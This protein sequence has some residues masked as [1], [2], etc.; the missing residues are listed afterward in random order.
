MRLRN[1]WNSL[2]M[3]GLVVVV[4]SGQG[5]VHSIE[6]N[7]VYPNNPY[8]IVEWRIGDKP[9]TDISHFTAPPDWWQHVSLIIKNI[10][11]KTIS[12]QTLYLTIPLSGKM[13]SAVGMTPQTDLREALVDSAQVPTGKLGYRWHPGQTLEF[14]LLDRDSSMWDKYLKSYDVTSVDKLFLDV[15]FIF[16]EDGTQYSFGRGSAS[17]AGQTSDP[18]KKVIQLRGWI[19][20][21]PVQLMSTA[22]NGRTIILD[23]AFSGGADWLAGATVRFK[24]ISA[25]TITCARFS[26]V[27]LESYPTGPPHAFPLTYGPPFCKLDVAK[28]IPPLAP[29]SIGEAVFSPGDYQRMKERLELTE[30][31]ETRTTAELHLTELYFAD[32][33]KWS[34]PFG[35]QRPDPDDPNRWMPEQKSL[36]LPKN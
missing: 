10:S 12:G 15:S 2:L 16:F 11:Q 35:Y 14:R 24:N 3:V 19:D 31:L 36:L 26:L 25:G 30:P 1:F 8:E 22:V 18:S 33:R 23:E 7:D 5:T 28:S 9:I 27:V 4:A 21:A 20:E 6:R 32:G 29:S 13:K 34:M 17:K